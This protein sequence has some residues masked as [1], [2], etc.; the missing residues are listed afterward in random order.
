MVLPACN[1]FRAGDHAARRAASVAP[2]TAEPP[3][4][5]TAAA[6][7]CS[8]GPRAAALANALSLF[9]YSGAPFGRPERGWAIYEPLAA[10]EIGTACPPQ[11][12]GFAAALARWR[13]A[14]GLP[15]TGVMDGDAMAQLKLLWQS[16]RP[17]VAVS[18]AGCPP[19][20]S[21]ANLAQARPEE[22]YGGKAILLRPG[23]L[24][25]YRRLVAA[26]RRGSSAIAGDPRLLTIFSG[27][28]SPAYDA[29]R[30][31]LQGNCQGVVRASCS[32]H[33]TGLAMDVFLGA[34]PGKAPD[35]S[36]DDNRL[37]QTRTP[38]YRWLV[39]N[40]ARFGFVN[41]PFEPWHWEW[42][43]ERP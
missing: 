19:P 39:A 9:N 7:D 41:Y 13:S 10:G 6:R 21:A 17:F 22:G 40:A 16:R 3:P 42:T 33:R 24:S 31:A 30:C 43:G 11:S 20:P 36:D 26:A 35:S 14:H 8:A 27:F 37:F 29:A 5:R 1:D 25:A 2:A 32:A 23:A 18:R 12:P 4:A 34:V 28:R 15:A 38:A